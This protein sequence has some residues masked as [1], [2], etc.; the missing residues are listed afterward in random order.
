MAD[1]KVSVVLTTLNEGKNLRHLLDSLVHQ[2]N[3]HEVVLVD[4]GSGDATVAV[5]E[6]Y[7][8]RFPHLRIIHQPSRRG[9]GRNIGAR[10]ATGDLLAFIDGDCVANAF[11]LRRLARAWDGE[12]MRVVAGKTDLTG[13]WA[14]T[15]LHR[16]ELPHRGQETTWPSCNLAYPRGLFER[17]GGFD[18]TFVTAE[19]IDLNFRAIEAGANIVHEPE[20]I[21]Y[22]KARDSITGFLRQAYWNGY[23]RKQLTV[24]HGKLWAQYSFRDLLSHIGGLWS[25]MRMV[26]GMVGYLDAK[27]GRQA[28]GRLPS[29]RDRRVPA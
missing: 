10:Q 26:V 28:P 17:L 11:W 12:P 15:Q 16:V 7:R 23:G 3:L 8:R 13:Y 2:E 6:S 5:A 18:P 14:F 9:E 21:V 22:A 19:D 20:A 27:M 4:A 1:V 24:K 29:D 25:T